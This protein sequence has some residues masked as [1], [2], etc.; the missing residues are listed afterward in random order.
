LKRTT[1]RVALAFDGLTTP[2]LS[3]FEYRVIYS[4]TRRERGME[5]AEN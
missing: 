4:H 1:G 5:L 2:V 3:S